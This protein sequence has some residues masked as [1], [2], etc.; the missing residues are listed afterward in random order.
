MD[1]TPDGAWYA[2]GGRIIFPLGCAGCPGPLDLPYRIGTNPDVPRPVLIVPANSGASPVSLKTTIPESYDPNA[3][4]RTDGY[5]EWVE[6]PLYTGWAMVSEQWEGPCVHEKWWFAP[7]LGLVKVA[8]LASG[9]YIAECQG[10]DPKIT[11]VRVQ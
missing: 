6:T 10:L 2:N 5:T 7:D 1:R 11:M 8:P 4:W 9:D 3:L